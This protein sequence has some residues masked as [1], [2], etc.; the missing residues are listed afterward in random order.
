MSLMQ[1]RIKVLRGTPKCPNLQT[2]FLMRNNLKV[3]DNGFFGFMLNL[4][5][6]NMSGNRNLE[7]LPEGISQLISLECLDLSRT[8]IKELP[9]ELK[10]LTKLKMLDLSFIMDLLVPR[11]LISSFSK[12][13]ILKM[14]G[15]RLKTYCSNENNVLAVDSIENENL[16]EELKSL[17]HLNILR[18]SKIESMIALERFL[19]LH[20]LRYSSETLE[21][22][23]FRETYVFDVLC[24]ENM[25]RLE[26][27]NFRFCEHMEE[28]KMGN[29]HTRVPPSTNYTSRFHTLREVQFL[30]CDKLRDVTWLI[31]A[32]NLRFLYIDECA[33]M[34]EI[35]REGK[36]GEVAEVV[37]TPFLKLERLGLIRLPE[38]K[39]IYWDALPFPCLKH[40]QVDDCPKLKKLPLNSDSAKGNHITIRVM[41]AWWNNLEWENEANRDAFLPSFKIS[42]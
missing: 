3:I 31:L 28:I 23:G 18:M 11:H 4:T 10:S 27:L 12:L 24:L 6:L 1:N 2:M 22:S 38:L 26:K 9:M 42:T 17:Q 39:S 7:A 15:S 14:W 19:S 40:I 30:Y 35:L 16:I 13:Q 36:L 5:V 37:P 21:L 25:E 20:L 8:G 32:P 34:E 33:K 29:L 41:Q